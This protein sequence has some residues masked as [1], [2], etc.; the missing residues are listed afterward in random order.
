MD[1]AEISAALIIGEQGKLIK[2]LKQVNT[3]LQAKLDKAVEA[4]EFYAEQDNS[5]C[6][7]ARIALAKIKD[8]K[9]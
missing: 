7:E 8:V 4:L 9:Q 5:Y 3:E 6:I 2:E 1:I